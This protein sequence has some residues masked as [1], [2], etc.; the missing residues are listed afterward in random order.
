MTP[1]HMHIHFD[2]SFKAGM[3]PIMTVGEPGAQGATVL[4]THGMGVNTPSAAEVAEATVGLAMDEHMPK[5]GMFAIGLKS[6]MLAAGAPH[7][8][9]FAGGTMSAPGA[10][11]KLHVIIAPAVTSFPIDSFPFR[12]NSIKHQ[13]S[14]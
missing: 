2:E 3:L 4:G 9:L 12:F 8:V 5:V 13:C 10:T 11:P 1:A 7:M 14:R 6:M